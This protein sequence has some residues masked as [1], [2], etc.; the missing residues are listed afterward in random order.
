M[1]AKLTYEH[2][3]EYV[4][5]DSNS[6]C[7]L[8]SENYENSYTSK[9]I[10]QCKCGNIFERTYDA[11]RSGQ[12]MCNNC[13]SKKATDRHLPKEKIEEIIR[14]YNDGNNITEISKKVHSKRATVS[15][16]LK[17]ENIKIKRT[18]EYYTSKELART[19][20][21]FFNERFFQ[22]IDN[23]IKAYWL[24]FLYADGCVT[25]SKT[26]SE[27]KWKCGRLDVRLK[28]DDDYM[29]HNLNYDMEGNVPVTY[30]IVKL[31]S[32]QKE[33]H[34]CRI[35]FNNSDLAND[36]ER[37]GCTRNKSLT[38]AFP[39]HLPENL[40]SH[41]MR[42]YI[43]GDGSVGRYV[44]ERNDTFQ[45]S[46]LGTKEFLFDFKNVLVKN[47]IRVT[48]ITKT[49]SKAYVMT[50]SGKENMNKVFKFLYSG[51]NR[52]LERKRNIF[53]ET[54]TAYD[55]VENLDSITNFY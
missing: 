37:H 35:S 25:Y 52:F 21:Y 42:G 54:L 20:K 49:K 11:F 26:K 23:P 51:A 18:Y 27:K 9:L 32:T 34:A 24:G 50:M 39:K 1:P 55:M 30:Y 33:Y 5:K 53:I 16:I 3:K 15:R 8:I 48:A 28:S 10:F 44:N 29:L 38:L 6:G 4:E 19:K 40:L 2:V 41:F 43:D 13:K 17:N 7:L 12:I 47:E 31:K 22:N 36:L 46:L 14:L 45:L